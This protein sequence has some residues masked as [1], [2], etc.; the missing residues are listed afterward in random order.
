MS[1][2]TH[3]AGTITI[4]ATSLASALSALRDDEDHDETGLPDGTVEALDQAF[5]A[6][7]KEATDTSEEPDATIADDAITYK[8]FGSTR[9]ESA[10][11]DALFRIAPHCEASIACEDTEGNVWLYAIKGGGFEEFTGRIVYD[12][13]DEWLSHH[14]GADAAG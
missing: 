11:T 5:A 7:F 14:S 9:V 2:T 13:L 12:G 6:M 4:A 10:L 8:V 1:S 3:Y